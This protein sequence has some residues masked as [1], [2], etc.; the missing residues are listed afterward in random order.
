[1]TQRRLHQQK[2]KAHSVQDQNN[3]SECVNSQRRHILQL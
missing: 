3:T 2:Y 1:V